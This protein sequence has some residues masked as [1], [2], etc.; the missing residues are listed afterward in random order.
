MNINLRSY[1]QSRVRH[2]TQRNRELQ[3]HPDKGAMA[4]VPPGTRPLIEPALRMESTGSA[5]ILIRDARLGFGD[6]QRI[7]DIAIR[8]GQIV[9]LGSA[10][11]LRCLTGDTTRIIDASGC[12]VLPG[13]CDSHVHLPVGAEQFQSGSVESVRSQ[14]ELRSY[15]STYAEENRNSPVL[16]IFGLHYT[17]PPLIPAENARNFLDQ[18]V[19]DKPLFIYAHDLH[20]GWANSN[21]LHQ[22]GLLRHMPPYPAV[23]RQL[24]LENNII[25]DTDGLPSGEL[26]EPP[27]YFLVEA[28]LRRTYP[29]TAQ[30]KL[31]GMRKAFDYLAGLGLTSVH[32]MGLDLPEEDI[33]LLMM[34]LELEEKDQL[35]LRVSS[36]F[37][38]VPDENMYRDLAQAIAIRNYLYK[39]RRQQVAA[40]E[41]HRYLAD[42][43][44]ASG[45]LRRTSLHSLLHAHPHIARHPSYD[46]L[47][48]ISEEFH[49]IVSRLHIE[50]Q[51]DRLA[52]RLAECHGKS[53]LPFGKVSMNTVK[54][55]LDGVIEKDTAFRLDQKPSAG[56]PAFTQEHLAEL[57]R[58]ADRSGLQV[59]AHSIGDGSVHAMLNAIERA[60]TANAGHDRKRGHTIRHRIEHIEMCRPE[61]IARFAHMGVV[62]S[63]QSLHEREPTTLW[64]T[65]VPDSEWAT[66]F[67]W[68]SLVA[69]GTTLLFGSDW[70]IVSC[71]CLQGIEHAITRKIWQANL[72]D[73]SL[74]LQQATEAFSSNPAYAAYQEQ[75]LGQIREGMLA[76][77]VVLSENINDLAAKGYEKMTVRH[78]IC[79]GEATFTRGT[80]PSMESPR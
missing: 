61:D 51:L 42:A 37:S 63:M 60:R 36:S 3:I 53:V 65:L 72:P 57:V 33:E 49:T 80:V 7:C 58:L 21:A 71:N 74:T 14:A 15:I 46:L 67:A 38:L 34:L 1:A 23:I 30:Q 66:A 18:L 26:R 19:S 32:T 25:L 64:H 28:Y 54:I 13:F 40:S 41:L 17:D 75:I 44:A 4:D 10:Q 24:H 73:Q 45:G 6:A 55:F 12:S 31:H 56:I 77:L 29:M 11:D 69:S 43:L 68:R 48:T 47:T 35:A 50:P 52:E 8:S 76:D 16:Y 59:A 27:V 78:T 79:N 22:A 62:A 9:A 39:A 2:L 5:D 70:P 20:T